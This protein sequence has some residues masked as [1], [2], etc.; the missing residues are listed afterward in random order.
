MKIGA[1]QEEC[2]QN[3]G[4]FITSHCGLDLM[5]VSVLMFQKK[6]RNSTAQ[7]QFQYDTLVVVILYATQQI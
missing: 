7:F 1:C 6:R 5:R 2:M 4:H 3:N